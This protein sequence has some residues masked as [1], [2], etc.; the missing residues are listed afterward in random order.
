MEI[1]LIREESRFRELREEWSRL[2][3]RC[4]PNH[5]F[6]TWEWCFTWWQHFKGNR[7]L[8]ILVVRS[9]GEVIGILPLMRHVEWTG[10]RDRVHYLHFIGFRFEQRW[11]DWMDFP[12]VRKPEVFAAA[13]DWLDR[14]LHLWDC[15]DLW[16]LGADS[17]TIAVLPSVAGERGYA[18]ELVPKTICPFVDAKGAWEEYY[19]DPVRKQMRENLDRKSRRFAELGEASLVWS[20]RDEFLHHLDAFFSMHE[21]RSEQA[22]RPSKFS[23]PG[24]REF[25]RALTEIVPE[26]WLACPV[27]KLGERVCAAHFGFAYNRKFYFVTPTFDPELE[28]YSP[29]KIL[30]KEMIKRCFE[31]PQLDEFDFLMGG[32]TYKYQWATGERQGFRLSVYNRHMSRWVAPFVRRTPSRLRRLVFGLR[33]NPIYVAPWVG[34][35][36]MP[37]LDDLVQGG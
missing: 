19:R 2:L 32:E 10:P 12:A 33:P 37:V 17:E 23:K 36:V 9:Q 20:S 15:F 7:E 29:G 16:D 6:M 8:F 35:L 28:K 25:Y 14:F 1:E 3:Q 30:L 13:L 31:N 26:E 24:Y 5:V 18:V 11:N 27:L 34:E 21:R 22:G 4:Q